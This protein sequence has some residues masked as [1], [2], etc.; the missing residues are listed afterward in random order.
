[1]FRNL[2]KTLFPG[3][4]Y[5]K[6]LDRKV[7]ELH[8][9]LNALTAAQNKMA[10]ESTG[11]FRKHLAFLE[12]PS[13]GRECGISP[14]LEFTAND[15]LLEIEPNGA[16]KTIVCIIALGDAYRA[17]ARA[18]CRL[19]DRDR[20][21]QQ[22]ET[23]EERRPAA[24]QMM[25]LFVEPE[26]ILM[27]Q[28]VRAQHERAVAVVIGRQRSRRRTVPLKLLGRLP[29]G[30]RTT[31]SRGMAWRLSAAGLWNDRVRRRDHLDAA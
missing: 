12:S 25:P 1:M 4:Y 22:I 14:A 26:P 10:I 13:P 7:A 20:A 27:M 23:F 30:D 24:A 17:A 31:L 28:H 19:E 6:Q 5:G 9:S 29:A 18:F 21:E 15:L 8:K 3:R 2:K 11:R 16:S